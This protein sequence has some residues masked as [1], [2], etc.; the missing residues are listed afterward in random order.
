MRAEGK[1]TLVLSC[2]NSL[3]KKTRFHPGERDYRR[4]VANLILKTAWI[5]R[6]DA[7]NVGEYDLT[8]GV[9]YLKSWRDRLS[10]PFV[11]AN[12]VDKEGHFVFQPSL[13]LTRGKWKIGVVGVISDKTRLTRV[14]DGDF[15]RISDPFEAVRKEVRLLKRK[16]ADCIVVLTDMTAMGCEKIAHL[17]LPVNVIIGS[18]RRNRV[19]LPKV[20]LQRLILHLDRYGKHVGK[21][22]LFRVE[23]GEEGILKERIYGNLVFKNAFVALKKEFPRDRQIAALM[24]AYLDR[25]RILKAKLARSESSKE[26]GAG[27]P[28]WEKGWRRYVGA[29]TCKKCHLKNFVQWSKTRHSKAFASLV[30]KGSQYDEDCIGCHSVGF[31]KKGG[32]SHVSRTM[33][34]YVNV[35]CEACHGPGGKHVKSGGDP[36]WIR[37][38]VNRVVCLRCHTEEHSPDF[39]YQVYRTRLSCGKGGGP[40]PV[41]E[42]LS[43]LE[44]KG[45]K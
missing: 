6:Y 26:E 12:F 7:I 41:G 34:R 15:Y 25:I 42:G 16:G 24:D 11:S 43:T 44:P 4:L 9:G 20:S 33:V 29:K 1:N 5:V 35:Q 13:M 32:F 30:R 10:L 31:G 21:L 18:D 2:G 37:K 38:A 3:F 39:L 27:S 8:L 14:P 19:S 28:S 23:N 40:P 17:S 45:A 22:T 36:R